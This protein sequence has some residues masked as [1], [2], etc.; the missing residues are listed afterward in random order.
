[1]SSLAVL[2][3]VLNRP[4][5]VAPL[6]ESLDLSVER[7]RGEGWDIEVVFV[8]DFFDYAEIEA[9][10]ETGNPP[11]LFTGSYAA[12]IN[13]AVDLADADWYLTAADDLRF[14]N[15]WLRAAIDKHIETGALVI[16][17]ND[18]HNPSVVR[19]YYATHLLIHRDYVA[20]GTIDEPGKIF[21]ELYR[22]N[23]VDTEAVETAKVRQQFAFAS[24][25][26]VE[27]LHPIFKGAPD[28][29]TYRLGREH[30]REDKILLAKRRRLWTRTG[31]ERRR[32]RLVPQRR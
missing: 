11:L 17:T 32:L 1:V 10:L 16:G 12:K 25:S 29:A 31:V 23:C 20:R 27:H 2:I 8:C 7:E 24:H 13:H 4:Q 26:H 14:H 15:G 9:V 28:D 5:N 3:P 19:G 21:C 6:V 22:H 18:L 30:H